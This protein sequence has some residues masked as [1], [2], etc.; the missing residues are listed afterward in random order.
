MEIELLE[1]AGMQ[2]VHR[3]LHL[4]FGKG[5]SNNTEKDN[6]LISRLVKAGDEHAKVM[7]GL[8]IWIEVN[9]P[10]YWWR[11]METYR[12]GRERLSCEST[13]HVDCKVLQDEELQK[14]KSEIP[15]G[16]MQRAV[17]MFS[18]QTLRRIYKQRRNHRLPEWHIFCKFIEQLPYAKEFII[19]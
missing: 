3:A 13:M 16:K 19:C 17:D 15:M 6:A 8:I 7:R 9:A 10:I 14:A 4:P 11:E 12:N 1:I 2:P 5:I 18:Y